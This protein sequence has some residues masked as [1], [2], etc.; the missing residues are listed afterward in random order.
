[1]TAPKRWSRRATTFAASCLLLALASCAELAP[2]NNNDYVGPKNGSSLKTL[3]E[4]EIPEAPGAT[5]LPITTQP[6]TT[7]IEPSS[8]PLTLAAPAAGTVGSSMITPL[9]LTPNMETGCCTCRFTGVKAAWQ[10]AGG[11]V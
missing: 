3:A 9:L 4:S 8:E 11:Q 5:T 10:P 7:M 6:T 1:M 2:T